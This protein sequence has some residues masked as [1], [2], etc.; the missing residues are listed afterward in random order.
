[1]IKHLVD[2]IALDE[3]SREESDV[4]RHH[5]IDRSDVATI[6][7]SPDFLLPLARVLGH[8]NAIRIRDGS[9]IVG[10]IPV[11]QPFGPTLAFP[12]PMCDY[13]AVALFKP[14][15][16]DLKS[17]LRKAGIF[18]WK[19]ENV[20]NLDELESI[21]RRFE[22]RSAPFVQMDGDFASY[23]ERRAANGVTF[24]TVKQM[25]RRLARE[26]GKISLVRAQPDEEFID[27]LLECKR[28][29][30]PEQ[31]PFDG[32]VREALRRLAY[33]GDGD[34]RSASY[35]LK[36]GDLDLAFA[37]TLETKGQSFGWFCSYAP[38]FAK[39]SPGT[40]MIL[41][42]IEEMH[43]R[44][45]KSFDLGPGGEPWKERFATAHRSVCLG[46]VYGNDTLG[47]LED[48]M[49]GMA[50]SIRARLCA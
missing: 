25:S 23:L 47:K 36:A 48:C 3:M 12:I 31:R 14:T 8:C 37:F 22:R 24:Q 6:C 21:S 2:V 1:M 33:L 5:Y 49:W 42:L 19:Y 9:E 26:V 30:Q 28:Y 38:S 39:Y 46:H 35:V 32:Y 11:Y 7:E 50:R 45:L 29:R 41:K 20:T 16:I 43:E 34:L 18:R 13:Q 10:Y 27:R 40:L 15:A 4:W 17:I 44:K